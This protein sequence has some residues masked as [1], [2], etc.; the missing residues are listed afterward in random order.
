MADLVPAIHDLFLFLFPTA[1]YL[2]FAALANRF[3]F[4]P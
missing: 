1:P 4:G 2:T 3:T